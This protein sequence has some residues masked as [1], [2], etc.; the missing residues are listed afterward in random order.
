[1]ELLRPYFIEKERNRKSGSS[2]DNRKH[3]HSSL[4]RPSFHITSVCSLQT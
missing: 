3:A 4:N 2:L 1:M